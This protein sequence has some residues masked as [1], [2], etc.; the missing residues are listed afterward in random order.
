VKRLYDQVKVQIAK[1]SESYAKQAYEKKY[2]YNNPMGLRVPI[3]LTMFSNSIK[4]CMD[5]SKLQEL[6]MKV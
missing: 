1:K 4:H 3:F 5:L 6:G 2:M